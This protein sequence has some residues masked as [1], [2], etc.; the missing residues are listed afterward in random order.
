MI[1]VG[2]CGFPLPKAKLA[3]VFPV[4][5]VQQTFYQ[6]PQLRTLERWRSEVPADFEYA[7]KAWQLITHPATS[8]TYRRLSK[9]FDRTHIHDAGSFNDTEIVKLAWQTTVDCAVVLRASKV[10]FQCPPSFLPTTPNLENMRR[11]F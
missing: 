3:E 4:A 9:R 7:V 11:F 2:T 8:P 6:P 10:L 5:E 1:K